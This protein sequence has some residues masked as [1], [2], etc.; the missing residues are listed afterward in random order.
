VRLVADANVLI[1]AV[2]GGRARLVLSHPAVAEVLAAES[3]VDDVREY[4]PRLAPKLELPPEAVL[5]AVAA[6]PVRIVEAS[7]YQPAMPRARRALSRRDPDDT[8]TLALALQ[9]DLPVW[10]NDRDFEGTGVTQHTTARLLKM[11]GR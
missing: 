10:S 4:A 8:D 9:F 3:V 1:S 2:L 11:L 7:S 6:L 5:L